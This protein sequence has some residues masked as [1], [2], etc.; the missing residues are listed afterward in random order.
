MR[1]LIIDHQRISDTDPAYV[2]AEIGHNHGG[3]T[4]RAL[5]LVETAADVGC[6]AAKFQK[7]HNQ[8]L[9]TRDMYLSPY[10]NEN[11]FGPTYGLH[12]DALELSAD[13]CADLMALGRELT[14]TV[15]AT[16][17]DE[18]SADFLMRL[19]VPA[20]KVASGDLK[21]TPLLKH[22]AGF[23][24]PM[25]VST[26]GGTYA[27]VDR[28]VNTIWPI[29]K[30]LALLHCTAAYPVHVHADLNLRAI[31]TMRDRY[32][33]LVIGWSGHDTGIAMP[34]MAYVLG[35]RI[36]EKH[37]TLNRTWKGTDQAFSLEPNGMRRLVRDL[38][39]AREAMGDGDK[40]RLA[41]EEKPLAKM[42]KCLV[43]ARPLPAGHLLCPGDL[44]ACSPCY[45]GGLPPYLLESLTGFPLSCD[46]LFEEP[47][48]YQHLEGASIA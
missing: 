21:N 36:I 14:F 3:D 24:L 5:D 48:T 27:D 18:R 26:G 15:F 6:S 23:G 47:V 38:G 13:G 19:R 1:D 4:Q 29:N 17:F 2:I 12:R 22:I 34:L 46:L 31:P 30:H 16:A 9:Y 35:A 25:I 28:A 37:F 45:V 20:F 7:R 43:A 33:E 41:C 8:T 11:S 39:R 32:P 10:D 42:E 40:R 44:K